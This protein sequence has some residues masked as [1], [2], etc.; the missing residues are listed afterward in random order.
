MDGYER[1]RRA[2]EEA[3]R[4]RAE[5]EDEHTQTLLKEQSEAQDKYDARKRSL[6]HS[7]QQLEQCLQDMNATYELNREVRWVWAVRLLFFCCL[8]LHLCGVCIELGCVLCVG[9]EFR[10]WRSISRF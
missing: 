9:C 5:R 8:L 3:M 6:E 7:V 4:K 1:R 10:S 2:E